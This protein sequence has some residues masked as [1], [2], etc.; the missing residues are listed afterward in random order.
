MPKPEIEAKNVMHL[1]MPLKLVLLSLVLLLPPACAAKSGGESPAL[2]GASGQ[3]P[4]SAQPP[5]PAETPQA[6]AA[7]LS[8]SAQGLRSWRDLEEPLANS[9]A[10]V[11][12]KP[13]SGIALRRPGLSVT[14]GQLA[15]SLERLRALLPRLDA[16][17]GL[18]ARQ[19]HWVRMDGG[20]MYTGYYEPVIPVARAREPGLTQP[21][22]GVPPDMA[23]AR[24]RGKRYHDRAAIDKRGVLRGKGLEMAW[25]DPV[26]AFFLQVQG[27]GRLRFDDGA[28]AYVN[29]AAQNGHKYVSIGRIMREQGLLEEGNINMPA[30]KAWLRANP[31]RQ[32]EM[33]MHNQSYVFFRWG[34]RPKG[35]MG[36]AVHPWVSLA[37]SRPVIPLGAVVAYGVNLPEES[38]DS[39]PLRG[40]GLAQDVGGAIKGNRIDI[41]CGEGSRAAHIAGHLDAQGEAWLLL[42]K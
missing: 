2:A 42:A 27:S 38:G 41:F 14:W 16:D 7:K 29:Y 35:A 21:V 40:I 8:P 20:M 1:Y 12:G 39:L 11:G 23:A 30:I 3:Y 22:Y 26:E 36:F 18:L 28:E 31:S 6:F 19:F 37:V 4:P 17:P 32:A 25:M 34:T 10:Y 33:F 24:K 15:N 13:A 5:F 9:I